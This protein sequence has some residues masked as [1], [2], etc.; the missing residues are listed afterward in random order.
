VRVPTAAAGALVPLMMPSFGLLP[1]SPMRAPAGGITLASA[2]AAA[3]DIRYHGELPKHFTGEPRMQAPYTLAAQARQVYVYDMHTLPWQRTAN[4]GLWLKPLRHDDEHGLYLGLVWFEPFTRSGLHQHR[5]V[6]TS[7]VVDGGLTDHHGS[8][9]LHQAGINVDGSTHDAVAYRNTVLVSRLEGPVVYPPASDISGMHAGSRHG[10][11]RPPDPD[12]P[13]EV[14]VT[15][16]AV[17]SKP[18][19]IPG[20]YRK[21][22]F[23]YDGTGTER[24]MVQ[25]TLHL[26]SKCSFRATALTEFWVRS[27]Q[28][29]VN[30]ATALANCFIICEPGAEVTLASPYGALLIGWA[31]GREEGLGNL[32]GF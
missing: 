8:I 26:E 15:V 1:A 29:L 31:E 6:A 16:D 23:D 7:F 10:E 18:T 3:E 24:R 2:L 14:N 21:M 28:V 25:L 20:I 17:V 27:G 4:P 12:I 5:G 32:F 22:V 30:G 9:V 11:F 13:P 19:G